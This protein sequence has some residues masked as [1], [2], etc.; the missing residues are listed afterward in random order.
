MKV[1]R[2]VCSEDY[3]WV[4]YSED[5]S[6]PML[7]ATAY[8]RGE[9]LKFKYRIPF[10]F[11]F[12]GVDS[13]KLGDFMYTN[14]PAL[15]V[16]NALTKDLIKQK[17]G[18]LIKCLP[19]EGK[20]EYGNTYY[21]FFPTKY[22]EFKEA[23][24]VDRS[25]F[26]REP[27]PSDL[28]DGIYDL[29]FWNNKNKYCFKD[30]VK[31]YPVFRLKQS[32]FSKKTGKAVTR[33][34]SS[35][36]FVLDEFA[37]FVRENNITGFEFKEVY[38]SETFGNI[39]NIGNIGTTEAPMRI[40]ELYSARRN[41]HA[42]YSDSNTLEELE[43]SALLGTD[44]VTLSDSLPFKLDFRRFE[45]E[46]TPWLDYMDSAPANLR[47]VSERAK[48]I[49][50]S[51]EYGSLLSFYP[52]E[53][54]DDTEH[55]YY[56]MV[57]KKCIHLLAL[58]KKN[59]ARD[60]KIP[61]EDEDKVLLIG[62]HNKY[63]FEKHDKNLPV[64]R[65]MSSAF[66]WKKAGAVRVC[67]MCDMYVL[68]DFVQFVNENG[69]TGFHFEKVYDSDPASAPSVSD[70]NPT[71][72]PPKKPAYSG[73]YKIPLKHEDGIFKLSEIKQTDGECFSFDCDGNSI[74]N[75]SNDYTLYGT[76]GCDIPGNT[77]ITY[78]NGKLFSVYLNTRNGKLPVYLV[79]DFSEENEP[80]A[81]K[82]AI[83]RCA[84]LCCSDLLKGLEEAN[85][86]LHK[87][88]LEY[89]YDGEMMSINLQDEY[90]AVYDV[91]TTADHMLRCVCIC[92]GEQHPDGY[93]MNDE[94]FQKILTL[95]HKKLSEEIPKRFEVT[96]DFELTGPEMYD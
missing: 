28:F 33:C 24:D 11:D 26:T 56:A 17:Y 47:L 92:A 44:P 8:L 95:L 70:V 14:E 43:A 30:I 83:Y 36:I 46:D 41:R 85:K 38:D 37:E 20:D 48:N 73:E 84:D 86:P 29:D 63:R 65:I 23:V 10:I 50:R 7:D 54:T 5:N 78:Q 53:G 39:G 2:I 34:E 94:T 32:G 82:E 45:H 12:Y 6:M 74:E 93:R 71:E 55:K 19:V 81:F 57:P 61:E 13:S 67:E 42:V 21:S 18:E 52:A 3:R 68:E 91:G 66:A 87:I 80:K 9:E 69:L 88:N 79:F 25:V 76:G 75:R 16:V 60:H 58:D 1:Y 72:P 77:E 89:Y 51:S 15:K 49:L 40:Y 59:I 22:I 64:F 96:E 35:Y 31:E 90:T 27:T 62:T 4:Y